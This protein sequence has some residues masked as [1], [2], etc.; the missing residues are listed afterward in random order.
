M[1]CGASAR[2]C[3]PPEPDKAGKRAPGPKASP[4]SSCS[5]SPV[6]HV[7]FDSSTGSRGTGTSSRGLCARESSFAFSP[8]SSKRIATQILKGSQEHSKILKNP[9]RAKLPD[10]SPLLEQFRRVFETLGD[11][12]QNKGITAKKLEAALTAFAKA[13]P[14]TVGMRIALLVQNL[15]EEIGLSADGSITWPDFVQWLEMWGV[16]E[17]EEGEAHFELF[18][19]CD[20]D[21]TGHICAQELMDALL[22]ISALA[23]RQDPSRSLSWEQAEAIV[24]DLDCSGKGGISY[25]E[26]VE[27]IQAARSKCERALLSRST[28]SDGWPRMSVLSRVSRGESGPAH[29]VLHFD[30]NNTVMMLDSATGADSLKLLGAVFANA[31]WGKAEMDEEGN[32][33]AWRLQHPE[34]SVLAPAAG[35]LTY[36]EFV[37]QVYVAGKSA[38]EEEKR[39]VKLRRK[40]AIWTF[41][42]PGQ[43]GEQLREKLE[44]INQALALP[45]EVRGTEKAVAAGLTGPTVQLLPS[46]LH[47]LR[48]LKRRERSFTLIFRTFGHDLE[49]VEKELNALCEGRHP[50]FPNDVV[51]DGSDG[52]PDYRMYLH[53]PMG[54]GTFYRNPPKDEIA[55]VMGTIR[56]PKNLAEFPAFYEGQADVT[57]LNGDRAVVNQILEMSGEHRTVALRDFYPAWASAGQESSAGKP[58]FLSWH[59]DSAHSIF[60]DDNISPQDPYIVDPINATHWPQRFCNPQLLGVHLVQAQPLHSIVDRDYFLNCIS[61]CEDARRAKLERWN[62]AQR[63]LGDLDSVQHLLTALVSGS[64]KAAKDLQ[65]DTHRSFE[66]WSVTG[67]VSLASCRP[68]FNE[69]Y[70]DDEDEEL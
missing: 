42:D 51:L 30:V 24:R 6:P 63:L 15:V 11:D 3:Q 41:T 67:K 18:E 59:A 56:Q 9:A 36:K 8:R 10:G 57:V 31:S 40:N 19:L 7:V 66:P 26:F 64:A 69:E 33:V 27:V 61:E 45:E 55:L 28:R 2:G 70:D 34:V 25:Q 48:E 50:L 49:M 37:D 13:L 54:C 12:V 20:A 4:K 35:L 14:Q 39:S 52:K 47:M 65:L 17:G 1:G 62:L 16:E 68:T 58:F 38:T 21:G 29:L 53:R 60:F 22:L 46:F 23:V 43:P 44:Q 5:T 32:M